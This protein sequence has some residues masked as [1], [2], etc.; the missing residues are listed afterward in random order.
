LLHGD[1]REYL[2]KCN[3]KYDIVLASGVL[4]HM[5]NPVELIYSI[6]KVTDCTFLWTHYYDMEQLKAFPNFEKQPT[7]ISSK[8]SGYKQYY[9]NI[10]EKDFY[11]GTRPYSIWMEREDILTVLRDAGFDNIVITN[12]TI[13]DNGLPHMA[14]LASKSS[15]IQSTMAGNK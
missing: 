12:D 3:N 15:S 1:F 9:T 10:G 8:Y 5:T 7:S 13:T 11:G 14:I 4:Y 2:R 6:A